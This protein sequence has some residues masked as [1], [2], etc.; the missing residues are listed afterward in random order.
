[1]TADTSPAA[2]PEDWE[3]V[4]AVVAHP[5]DLEFGASSAITRWSAQG[6]HVAELLVT[7]GEAGIATLEPE[8]C[9]ATRMNEQIAAARAVGVETVEFLDFPDG[10]LEYGLVLRRE[11]ARAIREHRPQAIISLNFR[12]SFGGDSFNHADHRVLG[13][14]LL[15]AVRDAANRWVFTEL[16]EEGLEPWQGVALVA[17]SNSPRVTHYVEITEEQLAAGIAS[18]DAHETY[19]AA[20]EGF[21]Q[22]GF[23]RTNAES[24][25]TR[26]GVALA[27]VF[28]VFRP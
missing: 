18:L 20:L 24:A 16:A 6:K 3:R 7:R 14:A 15:D 9:A 26:C 12:E 10:T 2:L 4:L 25:G 17:F 8:E 1:M 19:L 11:L 28:E 21:D 23:L 22:K 13:P 27:T 5:D